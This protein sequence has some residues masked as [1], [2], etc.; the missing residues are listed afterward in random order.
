MS[1]RSTITENFCNL[2]RENGLDEVYGVNDTLR[3]QNG[4]KFYEVTFCKARVLDALVRIY[5]PKFIQ[6]KW[7][8]AYRDLPH[9]GSEV[10]KSADDATNFIKKYFIRNQNV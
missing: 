9:N 1:E 8:T 7:Q 6:I 5:S 10:F 3:E 2:F 4:K